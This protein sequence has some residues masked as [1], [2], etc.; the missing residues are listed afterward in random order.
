MQKRSRTG[1]KRGLQEEMTGGSK[2]DAAVG[3]RSNDSQ[4]FG[5]FRKNLG[6]FQ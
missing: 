3:Q 5:H 4:W 2:T 6:C 1:Q